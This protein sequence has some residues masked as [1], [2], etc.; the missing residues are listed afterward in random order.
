MLLELLVMFQVECACNVRVYVSVAQLRGSRLLLNIVFLSLF[1]LG[2]ES[3]LDAPL[4]LW[5]YNQYA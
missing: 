2:F 5:V 1:G 3:A 4:C